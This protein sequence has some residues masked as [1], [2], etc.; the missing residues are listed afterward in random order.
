[1]GDATLSAR[2]SYSAKTPSTGAIPNLI[3]VAT[4]TAERPKLPTYSIGDVSMPDTTAAAIDLSGDNL[5]SG[6][7]SVGTFN[8]G[9]EINYSSLP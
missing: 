6:M 1:V 3:V 9:E 5:G 8:L 2:R 4:V 7:P